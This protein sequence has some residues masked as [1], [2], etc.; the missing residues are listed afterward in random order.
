MTE[1]KPDF[2]RHRNN[3]RGSIPEQTRSGTID[4]N[5]PGSDQPVK[6]AVVMTKDVGTGSMSVDITPT[7]GAVVENE[8]LQGFKDLKFS[9]SSLAEVI[10]ELTKSQYTV[11]EGS[12]NMN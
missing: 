10:A 5:I 3:E 6:F 9:G 11:V 2:W 8:A 7:Y 1:L 4:V 12:L